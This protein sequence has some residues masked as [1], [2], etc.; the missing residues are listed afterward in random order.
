MFG[1]VLV[2]AVVMVAVRWGRTIPC[3]TG[4]YLTFV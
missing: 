1:L 2:L 3:D 4:Y